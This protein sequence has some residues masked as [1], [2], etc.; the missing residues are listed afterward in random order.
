MMAAGLLGLVVTTWLAV[1]LSEVGRLKGAGVGTGSAGTV[2]SRRSQLAQGRATGLPS[3]SATS[4][5]EGGAGRQP[6]N[7]ASGCPTSTM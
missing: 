6:V 3:G 5:P 4:S 7:V 1:G 2:M